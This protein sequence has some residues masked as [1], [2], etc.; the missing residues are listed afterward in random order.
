MTK[1]VPTQEDIDLAISY[2][3]SGY[4]MPLVVSKFGT[5]HL[6]KFA[7]YLKENKEVQKEYRRQLELKGR[8]LSLYPTKGKRYGSG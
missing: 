6:S 7:K 8:Y 2:L 4:S 3:R 5:W 1:R